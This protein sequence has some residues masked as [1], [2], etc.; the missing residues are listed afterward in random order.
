MNFYNGIRCSVVSRRNVVANSSKQLKI[1]KEKVIVGTQVFKSMNVSH[2]LLITIFDSPLFSNLRPYEIV[3][4]SPKEIVLHFFSIKRF[5]EMFSFG[6]LDLTKYYK[7]RSVIN[8]APKGSLM[9]GMG[10]SIIGYVFDESSN[11]LGVK[12]CNT[13]EIVWVVRPAFDY[14]TNSYVFDETGG[15]FTL[16]FLWPIRI[17]INI[18]SGRTFLMYSY[19]SYIE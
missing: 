6:G 7:G 13:S 16:S 12:I 1:G 8:V 19:L 10:R 17:K 5:S 18:S 15:Q 3:Y 14:N 4:K 2:L 9:D 11:K